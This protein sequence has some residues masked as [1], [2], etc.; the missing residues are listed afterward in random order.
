MEVLV[1][2]IAVAVAVVIV[3]WPFLRPPAAVDA[4]ADRRADLEIA[5]QTKYREIRDLELDYKARK[6]DHEQWSRLDGELR[7]EALAILAKIDSGAEAGREASPET[8]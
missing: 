7:R 5:K 1:A 2:L 4:D 6:L 8:V 3:A